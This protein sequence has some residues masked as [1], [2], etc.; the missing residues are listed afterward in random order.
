MTLVLREFLPGDDEVL[1]SW[2]ATPAELRLFAGE[3]L[4]WPLDAR[5]LRLIRADTTLRAWTA[6][7]GELIIG[8][9]ELTWLSQAGWGRLARVALAPQWRGRGL[10][11]ELVEAALAKARAAGMRGVDL[12]VYAANAAARATYA[13]AGFVDVGADRSQPDLRWMVKKLERGYARRNDA[14][15]ERL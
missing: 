9:I 14:R 2:F 10:G 1:V 5:Q 8:H 15:R 4:R 12:R 7:D 11:R 13:A 3:S 6:V